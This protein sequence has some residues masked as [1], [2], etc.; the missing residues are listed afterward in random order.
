MKD[1]SALRLIMLSG[2][3]IPLALP[4]KINRT[5]PDA[6]VVSLG[7]ATEASI[8][9][10][11]YPI[12]DVEEGWKSIPYG[13]PLGNQKFYVLNFN[14]EICPIGV[15][16]ELYIGGE[17]VAEGY[18]GDEEKT[19]NAFINHPQFGRIYKTGDFGTLHR[20]GYIEFQGRKDCQV[21]IKG[22][23]I[24][25]GEIESQLM[26]YNKVN[27]VII[28]DKMDEEGQ[29][30]LCA[31]VESA[32]HINIQEIKKF[33]SESLPAYM[34]PRYFVQINSFPLT[35]NGKIDRKSLPS[36]TSN[37][38]V[39]EKYSK[40]TNEIED[41]L[42]NTWMKILKIDKIGI[43]DNFFELG[44]DSLDAIKLVTMIKNK[45]NVEIPLNYI[46]NKGSIKE[47]ALYI[48]NNSDVNIIY[49]EQK[50]EV[51][52]D[53]I[54]LLRK[55]QCKN[56]N[57]FLIHAGSGEI[58]VYVELCNRLRDDFNYW[59]IRQEKNTGVEAK[60]ITIN[61][62]AYKYLEGIKKVQPNG[63]YY[64]GGWCVGGTIAFEIARLLELEN[65]KVNF[66]G[67]INS[68][69]PQR[70]FKDNENKF[71][72][73]TEYDFMQEYFNE[74]E[75]VRN[76]STD[77]NRY[78]DTSQL[79]EAFYQYLIH[80]KISAEEIRE[81]VREQI[82]RL[83][84]YF[85]E[86]EI[87]ELLYYINIFRTSENA[88][89]CYIPP[90]NI[91][92]RVCLFEAN[93]ETVKNKERWNIYCNELMKVYEINGNHVSIFEVTNISSVA[94]VFNRVFTSYVE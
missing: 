35:A 20:E 61:E 91:N 10:I 93:Q 44:A 70:Y 9:S 64:I 56:K 90:N 26:K 73:Q 6:N 59:G 94:D 40:P 78:N 68:I 19:R 5:F 23:R 15:Q 82:G 29:K 58:Q 37:I 22:F 53:N 38:M 48:V 41:I 57:L 49:A 46:F 66:I 4:A 42:V 51:N 25:I 84:P 81:K 86:L 65:E 39:S 36:P 60:N 88:R 47:I 75:F 71:T 30:Y 31:Y 80:E 28:I 55:G 76:L 79:W 14:M 87:R 83:I 50:Q 74:Y 54:L 17:G 77:L 45:F 18:L 34:I 13:V 21:K 7:G 2:D 33:L 24:E 43:Q 32:E 69:A 62:W 12:S 11:Y 8:W 85:E 63:P 72:I 52:V 1:K 27:N 16:G 89:R 3:W 67:L 92:S